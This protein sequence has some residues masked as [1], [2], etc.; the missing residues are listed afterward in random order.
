MSTELTPMQTFEEKVKGRLKE[1]I[2][3]M[4]PDEVL[5]TLVHR[6]MEEQFFKP[7]VVTDRNGYNTRTEPPWFAVE[8]MKLAEPILHKH[9]EEAFAARK[10]E[11]EAAV[12]EFVKEQNLALLMSSKIADGISAE[13][14]TYAQRIIDQVNQQR[15]Y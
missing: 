3:D 9:I 2:A 4:L 6:V 12:A 5:S 15:R 1:T 14:F 8:V 7:K 10:D 11:I 13:M